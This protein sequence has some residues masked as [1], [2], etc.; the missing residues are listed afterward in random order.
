MKSQHEKIDKLDI[1][2][3]LDYRS[4]LTPRE[5]GCCIMKVMV[6]KGIRGKQLAQISLAKKNQR[7]LFLSDLT[8]ANRRFIKTLT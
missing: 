2:L 5:H 3:N 4:L 8:S 7:A 6:E 1:A